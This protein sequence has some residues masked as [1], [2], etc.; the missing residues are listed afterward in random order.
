[1][2]PI[3]LSSLCSVRRIIDLLN[4][5]SFKIDGSAIRSFPLIIFKTEG[6]FL[7]NLKKIS[8]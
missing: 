5:S 6:L 8:K 1:M 3:E 4:E 2:N 7:L